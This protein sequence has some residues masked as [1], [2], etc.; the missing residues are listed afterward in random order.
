MLI[1]DF[2]PEYDAVEKHRIVV[3][4]SADKTYSAIRT[5]DLG[6]SVPVK[7]LLGIR[8]LP[9]AL[10]SGGGGLSRLRR[11]AS[12][13][14]TLR[15]LERTGFTVLAEN[16]PNELLI[17][18]VGAFWKP[19]GGVCSTNPDHFR[20]PQKKGTARGAWNFAVTDLGN[21]KVQLSTET[22]VEPADPGSARAFRA[23]WIFV[24]P[25]SGLI[26]RYMLRAIRREAEAT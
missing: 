5:A 18:I 13:P 8:A 23:Y 26:R 21:G 20:G 17:G 1:D 24:R 2:L 3:C 15:D 9:G 7:M 14:V 10:A 25:G 16:P 19:T 4:A 11:R 6:G 22:R 12:E